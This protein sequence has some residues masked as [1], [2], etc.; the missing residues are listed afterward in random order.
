MIAHRLLVLIAGLSAILTVEGCRDA[1]TQA[2]PA[3][4]L[5]ITAVSDLTQQGT[6]NQLVGSNPTVRVTDAAG[7]AVAGVN[8]VF[9]VSNNGSTTVPT[10][11]DGTASYTWRLARVAGPQEV[12]AAI[13]SHGSSVVFRTIA[14]PD[15]LSAIRAV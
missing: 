10:G 7:H 15:S 14:L 11:P 9:D 5:S 2:A 1:T 6:V 4:N 8:V 13:S 3:R 12:V